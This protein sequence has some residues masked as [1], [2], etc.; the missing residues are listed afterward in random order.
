MTTM[1]NKMINLG[2]GM[3]LMAGLVVAPSTFAFDSAALTKS[4]VASPVSERTATA[5]DLVSKASAADKQAVAQA[6]VKAAIGLNASAAGDIVSMIA[7][8]NPS[9]ASIVAVTAAT[10]QPKQLGVITKAAVTAAPS[11]VANIVAALIKSSPKNYSVIADAA[12]EAAPSSSREILA[13]VAANVPNLQT[14]I[15]GAVAGYAMSD[16]NLPVQMILN[17]VST[18]SDTASTAPQPVSPATPILSPV[19]SGVGGPFQTISGTPT[20]ITVFTAE[21]TGTRTYGSY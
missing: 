12:A 19:G 8:Q 3:V 20:A 4:L 21:P 11:E 1:K 5:A 13:A 7:K 15:Q 18:S 9:L 2:A 17:Q 10:L 16:V 6:V 14:L